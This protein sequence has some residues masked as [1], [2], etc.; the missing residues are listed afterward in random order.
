[1]SCYKL[2][3]TDVAGN[4]QLKQE[5]LTVVTFV[6]LTKALEVKMC[7]PVTLALESPN[8]NTFEAIGAK[9]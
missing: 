8:E 9:G 5:V 3:S 1:M 7:H 4:N 6:Q 2:S